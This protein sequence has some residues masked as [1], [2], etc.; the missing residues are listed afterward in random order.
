MSCRFTAL[1]TSS[2]H[3]RAVRPIRTRCSRRW[4]GLSPQHR[5]IAV[6]KGE[7]AAQQA[8]ASGSLPEKPERHQRAQH[9]G[10][11]I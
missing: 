10:D 11:K 6:W 2:E 4:V 5:P 1:C 7:R 9:Q 3:R 8:R